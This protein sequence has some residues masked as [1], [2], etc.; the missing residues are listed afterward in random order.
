[1]F[2]QFS[3]GVI[4]DI[5][6]KVSSNEKAGRSYLHVDSLSLVLNVK[7]VNMNISGA[8]NNNRILRTY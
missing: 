7:D 5:T 6:G 2:F 8:F 4:A 3:E 1:M